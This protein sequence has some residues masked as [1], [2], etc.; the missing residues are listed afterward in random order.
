M[1]SRTCSDCGE[2]LPTE[3]FYQDREAC[4]RCARIERAISGPKKKFWR[5]L[6]D[7]SNLD[8]LE[9]AK[10]GYDLLLAK[11]ERG[12]CRHCGAGFVYWYRSTGELVD[13]FE[14]Q[15]E[16][17]FGP[18]F[19]PQYI[20]NFKMCCD[21]HKPIEITPKEFDM[22]AHYMGIAGRTSDP[23]KKRLMLMKAAKVRAEKKKPRK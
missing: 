3:Y 20:S 21:L 5:P 18:S 1:T 10:A 15:L 23:N 16:R 14:E 22:E 7:R 19:L 2:D 12:P 13:V 11:R 9:Q 17:A 8:L 6:Q 4:R